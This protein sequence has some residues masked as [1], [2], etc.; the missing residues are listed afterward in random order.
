[1]VIVMQCS[2]TGKYVTT[3]QLDISKYSKRTACDSPMNVLI[4]T[5]DAA[6]KRAT[7]DLMLVVRA[8][9]MM[10]HGEAA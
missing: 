10:H 9:L 7:T 4:D 5:D 8:D 6:T 2:S 3:S 1:M